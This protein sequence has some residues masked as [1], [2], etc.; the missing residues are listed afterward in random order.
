MTRARQSARPR[1]LRVRRVHQPRSGGAGRSV[2]ASWASPMSAI[3]APRRSA[4]TRRATSISSSTWSR[5]AS[6]PIS[7]RRTAP[8]PTPWP[9]GSAIRRRRWGWRSSAARPRSKAR[10]APASSKFRRSRGL[11]APSSIWSIATAPIRFTTSI[12]SRSPGAARDDNSVGL[13]TLDHLTHNVNRGRMDHWAHFYETH[14]QFPPDP[15]FRHRGAA[16]R[17]AHPGDDRAR[18]QDPHSAEREPGRASAR[19]PNICGN[20]R[21]KASSTSPSPPKTS[22]RP[23]MSC[24]PTASD[25]RTAPKPIST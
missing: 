4:I 15:L 21:A 22:S 7:A 2:H 1:R 14:L 24:A 6:R 8:R 17:A 11:A 13:Q 18:R 12:S 19:S 20:I 16:D 5:R 25:S 10:A 23:S 3:T 9:S